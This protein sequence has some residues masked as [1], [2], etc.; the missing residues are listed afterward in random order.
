MIS[1][2]FFFRCGDI[3]DIKTCFFFVIK[4]ARERERNDSFVQKMV[5]IHLT[6]TDTQPNHNHILRS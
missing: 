5:V 3:S 2:F 4:S 6:H 1:L